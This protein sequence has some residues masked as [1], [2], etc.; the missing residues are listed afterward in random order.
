VQA[1]APEVS[2]QVAESSG[3]YV[4]LASCVLKCCFQGHRAQSLR[5]RP[6]LP[7]RVPC[8]LV[9]HSSRGRPCSGALAGATN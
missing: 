4:I 2:A 8:T 3:D 9:P 6:K 7:S 5:A 1:G